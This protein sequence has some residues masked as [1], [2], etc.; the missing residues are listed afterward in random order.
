[1]PVV[2]AKV[3]WK[4]VVPIINKWGQYIK[5]WMSKW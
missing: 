5:T 4:A 1:M 3:I 2:R